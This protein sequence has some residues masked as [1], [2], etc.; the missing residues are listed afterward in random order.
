MQ[1]TQALQRRPRPAVVTAAAALMLL[2]TFLSVVSA[3]LSLLVADDIRDAVITELDNQGVDQVVVDSMSG[4]FTIVTVVSLGFAG[5]I[6]ATLAVLSIFVLRG[7]NPARIT[8]WVVSGLFLLCGI[9]QLAFQAT[10]QYTASGEDMEV[11][12]EAINRA[13][14]LAT[15]G[16]YTPLQ[17]SIIGLE[18]VS[19]VAIIVLLALPAA[20][21][22]F[23]K[24]VPQWHPPAEY[25]GPYPPSGPT[26]PGGPM[27]T[28]P[29]SGGP[30]PGGPMPTPPAMPG[31]PPYGPPQPPVPPPSG[32]AP[33]EVPPSTH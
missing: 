27:P 15:P 22:F 24:P 33:P 4:I 9:C 29:M 18:L 8:T 31:Q 1:P 14:E 13:A 30:M 21:A 20:N 7:A 23:A 10:G 26:M 2:V 19:F 32:D 17:I 25:G 16:W 3:I 11:D 28:T 5:L 6:A 12:A